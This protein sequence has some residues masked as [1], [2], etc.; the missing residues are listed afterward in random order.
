MLVTDMQG[1]LLGV[2][3]G[4]GWQTGKDISMGGCAE[5]TSKIRKGAWKGGE[6]GGL[7]LF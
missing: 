6:E 4:L 2:V 7:A 5:R 3:H 1:E